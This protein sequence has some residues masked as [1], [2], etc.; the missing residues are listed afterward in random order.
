MPLIEGSGRY[1]A[2]GRSQELAKTGGLSMF[3]DLK[4]DLGLG[5]G[6]P[7][8]TFASDTFAALTRQQWADFQRDIAP[9]ENKLI[10]FSNS[11]TAATDAMNR[12]IETVGSAFDRQDGATD[13]RLKGLGLTLNADEQHAADRSSSLAQATAEV[14]AANSAGMQTRSLQQALLGNPTP[15]IQAPR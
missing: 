11:T 2:D 14:H 12:G 7:K 13:S 10:E 8:S 6:A 15:N 4:H 5:G 9:Y 3:T 1:S